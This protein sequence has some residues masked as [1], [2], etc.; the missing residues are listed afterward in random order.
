MS[1]RG[2]GFEPGNKIGFEVSSIVDWSIISFNSSSPESCAS[3]S[4]Q[5]NNIF[6]AY[7]SC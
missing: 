5:L 7:T 4:I 6:E 3:D 2:G 1:S